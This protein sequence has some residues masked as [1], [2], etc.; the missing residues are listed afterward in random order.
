MSILEKFGRFDSVLEPGIHFVNPL[1]YQL[2]TVNWTRLEECEDKTKAV[3]P[4]GDN[5]LGSHITKVYRTREI[6]VMRQFHVFPPFH[7]MT[8]DR[9]DI[10]INGMITF[11]IKE[12]LKT[13]YRIG[14]PYRAME[15]QVD[16]I[17]RDFGSRKN[18]EEVFQ[19]RDEITRTVL[20]EF[21]SYG[22]E[23][24][25][26]VSDFRIQEINYS[27]TIRKANEEVIIK[28]REID[29]KILVNAAEREM[30]L[31]QADTDNLVQ[32]R[33]VETQ[34]LILVNQQLNEKKL[35]GIQNEILL[36]RNQTEVLKI[37]E[38]L[39]NIPNSTLE[40]AT[41]YINQGKQIDAWKALAESENAK[42]LMPLNQD[43]S[44]IMSSAVQTSA[45]LQSIQQ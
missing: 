37:K 22:E 4:T 42:V 23:W 18:A 32:L 21:E 25:I 41:G 36:A 12:P 44:S 5:I 29:A 3:K 28:R 6:P 8:L 27:D 38:Y 39:C 45:V 34:N 26:H 17:V 15:N 16:C 9:L 11:Q 31:L 10:Y 7:A 20:K 33:N 19:S 40:I 24:G 1:I 13:V 43:L 30:K 35:Q 2:K 14:G